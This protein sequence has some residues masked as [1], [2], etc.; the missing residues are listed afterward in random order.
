MKEHF[1]DRIYGEYQS[2]KASVLEEN[3]G[4]IYARCYEIDC[5]INLYE[6]LKEA[7]MKMSD[8]DLTTLLS[9]HDILAYLYELWM[10]KSDNLYDEMEC[11]VTEELKKLISKTRRGSERTAA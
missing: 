10:K 9:H 5:M 3:N 11:H 2:Y 1:L 4:S 8:E 6:I 7:T